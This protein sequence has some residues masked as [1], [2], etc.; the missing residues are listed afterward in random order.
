LTSPRP[1]GRFAESAPRVVV[2]TNVWVSGLISP[3]GAPGLVVDAARRGAITVVAS[4]ELAD[5]I[6]AVLTRPKLA[7]RYGISRQD[8]DDIIAVLAPLLP[9]VDSQVDVDIPDADDVP[10]LTT[11]VA[12]GA[13]LIVTGDQ[14]LLTDD[15]VGWLAHRGIEVLTPAELPRRLE[16]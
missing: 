16:A 3:A 9:T 11:A 6:T 2:D 13:H 15:V 8:V 4:W 5:E 12:G 1:S 7:E 14:D 10:V